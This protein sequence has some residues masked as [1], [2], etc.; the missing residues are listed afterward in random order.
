MDGLAV[1][2]AAR[3]LQPDVTVVMITAFATVETAVKAMKLGAYDYIVKPFDP[4]ELSL[5]MQKVV[6]QQAV[7]R[8]NAMLRKAL[9]KGFEF[10]DITSASPSMQQA[11]ELARAAAQTA[12]TVLILGESGTGK[13]VLAR[14]IHAESTRKGPFVPVSCAALPDTL[15]ESELFGHERGAFTGAL[16]RRKGNFEAAD[17]GTLFLDEIGD[18]SAKLQLDL[19]RVLEERKFTRLGGTDQ[20]EV[21]VRIIAATNRNLQE[22]VSE[23]RFREDLFYRLNVIP[24]TLP[25]LRSRREDLPGLVDSLLDRLS[26]EM[27]R[28]IEGVTREAMALL[29]SY[30]FPGNVRELR[31]LLERAMVVSPGPLIGPAD[32]SIPVGVSQSDDSLDSVERLHITR[33]LEQ[34]GGNVSHA[35]RVLGIDRVTLYNKIRKYGLRAPK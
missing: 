6:A 11:L 1:L 28:P 23:G 10:Q 13:E 22:A 8:E 19:L 14:A 31:N 3:K 29:M 26:V 25:P 5:L 21:D 20:V 33:I 18:I 16:T 4:E 32:L 17:G 12:S 34:S 30:P 7:V 2:E 35:A 15:L 9:R 24:I 27:K